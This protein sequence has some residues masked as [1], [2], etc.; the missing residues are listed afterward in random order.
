MSQ[1]KLEDIN[2]VDYRS[3]LV[4]AGYVDDALR[5]FDRPVDPGARTDRTLKPG[6]SVAVLSP[7]DRKEALIHVVR[8][9][10]LIAAR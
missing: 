5:V 2:A 4:P 10:Q 1:M 9:L 3:A 7:E 8:S 6:C